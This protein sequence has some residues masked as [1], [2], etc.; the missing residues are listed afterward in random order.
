MFTANTLQPTAVLTQDQIDDLYLILSV[1]D[2]VASTLQISYSLAGGSLLGAVRHGGCIPWDSNANVY[3]KHTD[4]LTV[5]Y[6]MWNIC[7]L[8]NVIIEYNSHLRYYTLKYAISSNSPVVYL[9]PLATKESSV[10][11]S[12][13]T[14]MSIFQEQWDSIE[15]IPFGILSLPV[16]GD[17][18][19]YL[20]RKY[21]SGW[22]S[23][24]AWKEKDEGGY[25]KRCMISHRGP[26]F[27]ALPTDSYE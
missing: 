27:P 1:F 26:F 25:Q 20:T 11:Y 4:I 6:A 18:D 23:V 19:L 15:R 24:I 16:L 10:L 5:Q 7:Q 14:N 2:T 22:D 17:P 8:N 3:C 12:E 21:G 13:H 9:Y